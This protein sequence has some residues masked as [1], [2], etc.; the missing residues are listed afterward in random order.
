[1]D[2]L[3]FDLDKV[4]AAI[5]PRTRAILVSP[6]LGNAPDMDRIVRICQDRGLV[7]LLDD[8]D[9]LGSKW[10][11]RLLNT[12]AF[13]S[14]N[15]FYSSHHL[16]TGEGG[17]VVSDDA[18][19]M[20]IARSIAWWGRDCFCVGKANLLKDG[21]CGTRFQKWLAPG[22]DEIVDHRYVFTQMGYNLKPLDLQG[23]IGSVQLGRFDEI[24]ERRRNA[25]A[26]ISAALRRHL[27]VYVPDALPQAE[28]SWF[29]VPLVCRSKEQKTR[30]VQHFENAKIQTRPYFAGNLLIQPGYRHLGDYREFPNANQV[31]D[32]VFFIGSA[33]HYTEPVFAYIED[34]AGSFA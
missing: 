32:R 6:V 31:L 13:A 16:C 22:Y 26:R 10:N 8:C 2:S 25:Y 28:T 18:D 29:G 20:K 23:A 9:S 21:S 12:Y 17:M 14:S 33:P 3:N 7:F 19:Y 5:T 15:S 4:E 1:M 27:D 30:L 34:V 11:G 24:H